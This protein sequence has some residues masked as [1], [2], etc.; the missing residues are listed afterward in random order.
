[1]AGFSVGGLATGLDTKPMIA[2][3]LQVERSAQVGP[4]RR[5]AEADARGQAMND[6]INLMKEARTAAESIDTDSEAAAVTATS[7]DTDKFTVTG[8]GTALPGNYSLSIASLARS[9]KDMAPMGTSLTDSIQQGTYT[10]QVDGEDAVDFVLDGTN[11]TLAGFISA[12]N[13]SDAGVTASTIFDGTNYTLVLTAEDSG[14]AV[15]YSARD[16]ADWSDLDGNKSGLSMYESHLDAVFTID[17][18]AI[19]SDSNE[20]TDAVTGL[21]INLLETTSFNDKGEPTELVNLEVK[22]DSTKTS[23]NVEKLTSAVGKILSNLKTNMSS[24]EDRAGILAF[25]ST[26]RMLR[27]AIADA[28]VDRQDG[29]T[30]TYNSLTMIGIGQDRYGNLSFDKDEF[31]E[32]LAKD[33]DGVMNLI[34]GT[35]GLAERFKNMADDYTFSDGF[36]TIRKTMYSDRSADISKAIDRMEDRVLAYEKRLKNQFAKLEQMVSGLNQQSSA[37][38]RLR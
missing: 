33:K 19:T 27:G 12:I 15:S 34:T 25:D 3:L 5:K 38:S 14:K 11:D 17:G 20:I 16:G 4:K 26:A 1:M 35:D 22:A 32:A 13:S 30:G 21:T 18:I 8:D 6:L 9:Q 37:L 10:I 24:S 31:A 36:L 29:N 28:L 23:D 7:N 2:Q